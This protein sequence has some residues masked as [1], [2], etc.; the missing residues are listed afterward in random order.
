MKPICFVGKE[1]KNKTTTASAASPPPRVVLSSK[2]SSFGRRHFREK[3][4]YISG[5]QMPSL[6]VWA[7]IGPPRNFVWGFVTQLSRF[8]C[9]RWRGRPPT[10]KASPLLPSIIFKTM[11]RAALRP[12]SLAAR[13]AARPSMVARTLSTTPARFSGH[14]QPQIFGEGA[15]SGEVPT[16]DIQ[17]TGLERLQVLGAKEGVDVFDYKPLDSSR[18]GTLED[19]VKVFSWVRLS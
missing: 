8:Y 5:G 19:P 15:K 9:R 3:H 18:V 10:P 6:P 7:R 1:N 14:P 12:V 4:D 13:A 16:D 2:P 17:A 11:F